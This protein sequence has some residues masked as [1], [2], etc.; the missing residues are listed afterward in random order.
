VARRPG[1]EAHGL[2]TGRVPGGAGQFF[3]PLGG[4]ELAA[5]R[6]RDEWDALADLNT[7]PAAKAAAADPALMGRTLA[8]CEVFFG[9][10]WAWNPARWRTADGGVDYYTF[11]A[12]VPVMRRL[13]AHRRLEAALAVRLGF[14]GDAVRDLERQTEREARGDFSHG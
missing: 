1:A 12:A 2:A 14:G 10:A 4:D 9:P 11:L 5:K 3:R 6:P 8:S 13:T 7:D